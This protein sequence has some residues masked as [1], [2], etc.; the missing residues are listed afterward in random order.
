MSEND[1]IAEYV[2]AR[3]P[4]ILGFEF[5]IW[6]VQKQIFNAIQPFCNFI[7]SLSKEEKEELLKTMAENNSDEEED[8]EE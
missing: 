1:Y 8:D 6:K 3:H 7:G 5:A 2:K 4:H